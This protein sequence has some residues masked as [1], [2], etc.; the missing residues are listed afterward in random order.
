MSSPK[1]QPQ[2]APPPRLLLVSFS[3]CPAPDRHGVQLVNLLKTLSPRYQM[4]VL[5][6]RSTELPYV[7]RFHRTRML[8]VPVGQG[9]LGE[10]VEAFRRAI[11]RQFE[12]DEYDVV[13]LRSAWGGH[14]VVASLPESA[15]LVYEVARSTE[16]EPR[17]ADEALAGKLAE[18]E[19]ACLARADLVLVPTETA[20][21]HL[22]S[23]GIDRVRVIAPGVNID[24]FDWEPPVEDGVVRV[25]YAG[26]LAA[27]RGVRLLLRA[28][29]L[30]R[31]PVRLVLA[32]PLDPAFAPELE[33]AIAEAGLEPGQV[34]LAGPIEHDDMP[35]VYAQAQVCVAPSSPDEADR[36][37]AGF[38]TKLLEYLA[39]K[40]AVIAPRRT[41]VEEVISDEQEGLLFEPGDAADLARC[42]ARLLDDAPLREALAGA[43]WRRVRAEHPASAT[44]RQ[45]LEA[46]AELVPPTAWVPP[47]RSVSPID[48]LP[49]HP[50]TTTARRPAPWAVPLGRARGDRSGEIVVP[51]PAAEVPV[52]G[53]EIVIEALEPVEP[54]ETSFD[55]T[56]PTDVAAGPLAER[57]VA[58]PVPERIED[59]P[60]SALTRPFPRLEPA[61]A[62]PD[63]A[64]DFADG[65]AEERTRRRPSRKPK[66]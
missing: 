24:H 1:R 18:E 21:R 40:K 22:V 14:A 56:V 51:P 35:R 43:G 12:G 13:H 60:S 33:R 34:E 23:R 17:A 62:A 58:G 42:L 4:D 46:Y 53:G 49:A 15:R 25:L 31:R 61:D 7:E 11:R 30:L 50:D 57:V 48:G 55:E 29:G 45:V 26:R 19:A 3:V 39:C 36:P 64:P 63:P 5:T 27:G 37:L 44:R 65:A 66:R 8:R 28:V 47:G 59:P 9:S 16:G 38:P 54:L 10:Q 2:P 32:G 20:R 6:L 52:V 41:S